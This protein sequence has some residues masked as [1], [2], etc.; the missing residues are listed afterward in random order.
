MTFTLYKPEKTARFVLEEEGV[1]SEKTLTYKGNRVLNETLRG[2]YDYAYL[3]LPG[4]DAVQQLVD[5]FP[6][7]LDDIDGFE[8]RLILTNDKAYEHLNVDY[9]K[10]DIDKIKKYENFLFSGTLSNKGVNYR[11]TKKLLKQHGYIEQ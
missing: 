6:E 4:K 9:E 3:G 7:E 2:E 10:L 5:A 11:K 1:Y 8:T